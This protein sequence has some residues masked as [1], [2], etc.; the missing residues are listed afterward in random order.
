MNRSQV[1]AA[2][3]MRAKELPMTKSLAALSLFLFACTSSSPAP[4]AP[5]QDIAG[6]WRFML[7]ES[8]PGTRI[9]NECAQKENAEACY[10]EAREEASHEKIRFTK[11]ENGVTTYTA[12]DDEGGGKEKV[13]VSMKVAPEKLHVEVVDA[14]TLAITDPQKGRLV[15]TKQ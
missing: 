15:F 14:K 13:W 11:V 10:A 6:T 12:F 7:D 1:G 8:D 5:T 3:V 2:S 4:Q 9:K